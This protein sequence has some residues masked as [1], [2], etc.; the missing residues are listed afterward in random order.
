MGLKRV[1]RG[2]LVWQRS[3]RRE[4]FGH[5]RRL[6]LLAC[7]LCMRRHDFGGL[8]NLSIFVVDVAAAGFVNTEQIE[9]SRVR[10]RLPL[11]PGFA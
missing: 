4:I 7:L 1:G 11:A 10:R 5:A 6:T 8:V 9:P 3:C 2:Q